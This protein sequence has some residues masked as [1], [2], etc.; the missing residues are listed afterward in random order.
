MS[1]MSAMS[2][3]PTAV[4][5]VGAGVLVCEGMGEVVAM[6]EGEDAALTLVVVV[7]V[8]VGAGALLVGG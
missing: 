3:S 8:G 6:V 5:E 2:T 1:A 7:V 4:V